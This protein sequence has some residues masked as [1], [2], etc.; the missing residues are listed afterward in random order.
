MTIPQ[1]VESGN[2]SRSDAKV[3]RIDAGRLRL[4]DTIGVGAAMDLPRLVILFGHRSPVNGS[5]G[6]FFVQ[7]L[8]EVFK[9]I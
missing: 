2:M 9:A 4:A 7:V 8:P 6:L 5:F 1:V 3:C